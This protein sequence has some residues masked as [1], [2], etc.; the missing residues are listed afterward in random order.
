MLTA[1]YS[2]VGVSCFYT[3]SS[4]LFHSLYKNDDFNY[5]GVV[6]KNVD[7]G[8]RL[9]IMESGLHHLLSIVKV[10]SFSRVRLFVTP[11]TVA[12]Q[13]PLSMGFSRQ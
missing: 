1:H 5:A 4:V 12:H 9:P 11:W 10:K 7:F 3:C 6:V 8:V 13:A 2:A